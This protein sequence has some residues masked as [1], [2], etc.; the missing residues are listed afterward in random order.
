MPMNR[1]LLG[2]LALGVAL[3]FSTAGAHAQSKIQQLEGQIKQIQRNYQGQ[4]DT[5]QQQIDQLKE[6][7][8]QQA[9][10]AEVV[11]EQAAQA[12]AEVQ[13]AKS[14]LGGTYHVGG[15][16]LKVGGFI[17]AATI[18]RSS[19]EFAD[20]GSIYGSNG[21]N[22]GIPLSGI[23]STQN[24]RG[25]GEFRESARQSRLSL[26][27]TGKP[28]QVT[29]LTAY[30]ENDWLGQGGTANSNESNSYNL[31][32]R[33]AFAMYDRADWGLNILGGQT[34]SLATMFGSGMDPFKVVTPLSIDAQYNV[35]F[36]WMRQPQ[37]RLTEHFAPGWWGAISFENSQ[38]TTPGG[39]SGGIPGLTLNVKDAAPG[40]S[41]L[42]AAGTT[43][44]FDGMPDIVAKVVAEPGWGHFELYGLVRQFRD[45][46]TPTA[47]GPLFL[48][49]STNNA[50]G[51]G[52]GWGA[53]LPVVPKM[54]DVTVSGLWGTGIGKYASAQLPDVAFDAAGKPKPIPEIEAMVGVIGHPTPRLDLYGYWGIEHESKEAFTGA[55]GVPLGYGNPL[56]SNVGCSYGNLSFNAAGKASCNV[57]TVWQFQVGDW[58]NFYKGEYGRMAFGVSYSYVHVGTFQGVGGTPS[59]HDNIVMTSFRYYPF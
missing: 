37:M 30:W 7:Q 28:D 29:T 25:L 47:T 19:N 31:R 20:V 51:G 1:K 55:G 2:G 22:A 46:A 15:V 41:L 59:G 10:Q 16:T 24:N 11:R 5:L 54:I 8:R 53:I 49:S 4:I 58:W 38:L 23:T 13:K 43:F 14:G 6:Q 17:E 45:Q 39:L 44:S 42:N 21:A 52:I 33:H 27:A 36:N 35:G 18:F 50:I 12:Q 26:L 34:W 40:G 32:M 56:Y 3:V 57:D 9:A 48:S